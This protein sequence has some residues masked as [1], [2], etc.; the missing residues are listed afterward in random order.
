MSGTWEKVGEVGV[1]AGCV[2]IG[3]L[4]ASRP[5]HEAVLAAA[6]TR[7]HTAQTEG[8]VVCTTGF[9]DGRYDVEVRW[10]ETGIPG[11]GRRPAELRVV[12]IRPED[13]P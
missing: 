7:G 9:G 1:D 12:F 4:L 2:W 6:V 8:G 13:L 11:F 10:V 5:D 3:D